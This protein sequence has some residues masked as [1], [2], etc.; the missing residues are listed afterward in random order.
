MNINLSQSGPRVNLAER[1]GIQGL[2]VRHQTLSIFLT[3]AEALQV[4][5]RIADLV[6]LIPDET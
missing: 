3:R 6:A 2:R 5:H 1:D 4:A